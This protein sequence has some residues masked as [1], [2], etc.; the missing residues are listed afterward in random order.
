[1]D[2]FDVV[3][4]GA[5][6][7]GL[8][9]AA[10]LGRR[11]L[12]VL[13]VDKQRRQA[14]IHKGELLQPRSVQILEELG[15]LD[16]LR[17]RGAIEADALECRT[18]SGALL[19][20]LDYR[21]LPGPYN[22]ALVHY[23]SDIK[24]ALATAA[25]DRVEVRGGTAVAG[26]LRTRDGRV[27]GVRVTQDGREHEITSALTVGADGRSSIV[28]KEAGISA[29]ATKYEH[30]LLAFD[31]RD[32]PQL[33]A[34]ITALL[35]RDGLRL[36]YPMPHGR[37]RL[38]VQLPPGGYAS[39]KRGMTAWLDELIERTPALAPV[40]AALRASSDGAQLL[41]AWRMHADAWCAPGLALVG[42]A[43]HCV[44]PMAAQ[45]MN[46]TI[47]DA[48]ALADAL[49]AV[50]R[51]RSLDAGALDTALASYERERSDHLL[52]IARLS[53]NLARLF[54]D[55]SAASRLLY[56]RMLSRNLDNRRLQYVLTYNVSGLGVR[57]FTL[58]DRVYQFGLMRD[59][60]AAELT[61]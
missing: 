31:I 3:V 28:R 60:R 4:C 19:V 59:P 43:A 15:A 44:H 32:A 17:A 13:V 38:Y 35:T 5:G 36:L 47:G 54:T 61:L 41:P 11:D 56:R 50:S 42:D 48:R 45:G 18:A 7:G 57:R 9:L 37:A 26:L 2:D 20:T 33:P 23:Y 55:T 46:A 24:A 53:H 52:Y 10:A 8:A 1:M 12:R 49:A 30:G 34:R 25:G 51:G 16:A 29:E 58:R 27:R 21:L 39:V 22:A 40:A 6:A 14:A